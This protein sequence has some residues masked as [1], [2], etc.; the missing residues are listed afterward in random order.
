MEKEKL[1]KLNLYEKIQAVSLEVNNISKSM[2]VGSGNYSYKAVGDLDVTLQ[3]K[4]AEALHKVLSIPIKQ[5][6][7]Q[8]EIL[9]GKNDSTVYYTIVKMITKIVDLED[10]SQTIEIESYGTG[11]DN[12]DKG[13]GKASTYAR[14]YALLNAYK[15][16]TGEDPDAVHS[17]ELQEKL[18]YKQKEVVEVPSLDKVS[19]NEELTAE[20][21]KI[22]PKNRK[23]LDIITAFTG[24]KKRI[25]ELQ[26]N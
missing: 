15:I 18:G 21:A 1:R 4:K 25:N 17:E 26:K 7:V 16:A 9:K 8:H 12:G 10:I 13:M 11:I 23:N 6:I 22:D 19:T 3:V 20:W 14:K 5:E 2:T 24:A